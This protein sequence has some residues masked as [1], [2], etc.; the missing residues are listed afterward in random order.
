MYLVVAALW[1]AAVHLVILHQPLGQSDASQ[2][3]LNKV[4]D[5]NF[6]TGF[7]SSRRLQKLLDG[8]HLPAEEQRLSCTTH[9][10]D[11]EPANH[12]VDPYPQAVLTHHTCSHIK[13]P[14]I[15]F[16]SLVVPAHSQRR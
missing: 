3:V 4:L 1:R 6:S 10:T 5:S 2:Q 8:Y 9:N 14:R 7:L 15:T 11:P 16:T 12:L 13:A